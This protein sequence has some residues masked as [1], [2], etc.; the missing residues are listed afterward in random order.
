M[1]YVVVV[2]DELADLMMT[3][4]KEVETSICRLAQKSRAVGIHVILAT[5]RPSVD[6]ITGLIKSNMPSRISFRVSS[7]VDSRTILDQMG[8]DRLLGQGRHAADVAAQAGRRSAAR[9]CWVSDDE[10]KQ[11]GQLHQGSRPA[12]VQS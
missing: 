5:Q 7:K 6:V 9:R 3:S 12:G 11:G 8:A 2:V 10:I 4:A 1:P